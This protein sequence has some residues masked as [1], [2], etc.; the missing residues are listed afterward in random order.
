MFLFQML[1]S[2]CLMS[3]CVVLPILKL[4]SKFKG[5]RHINSED[6]TYSR[7]RQVVGKLGVEE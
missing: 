6:I 1:K 3:P 4:G 5:Y 2:P 7:G